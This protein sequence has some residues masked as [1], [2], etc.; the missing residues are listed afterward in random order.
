MWLE[1]EIYI[2]VFCLRNETLSK[3]A[4]GSIAISKSSLNLLFFSKTTLTISLGFFFS[5]LNTHPAS[6]CKSVM[7]QY[8]KN[9]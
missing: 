6:L 2:H 9:V 3:Y 7:L 8:G 5:T 4:L 1:I